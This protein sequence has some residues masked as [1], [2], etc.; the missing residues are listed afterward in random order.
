VHTARPRADTTPNSPVRSGRTV[1]ESHANFL[2]SKPTRTNSRVKLVAHWV[3]RIAQFLCRDNGA[4]TAGNCSSVHNSSRHKVFI[5]I[6]M[7]RNGHKVKHL[8]RLTVPGGGPEGRERDGR[9]GVILFQFSVPCNYKGKFQ[10]WI[11]PVCHKNF[12][13]DFYQCL[14][15]TWHLLER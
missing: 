13:V 9:E 15:N 7:Q 8:V 14:C 10:N 12:S 2:D 4:A 6:H 11:F 1:I 3:T 5:V